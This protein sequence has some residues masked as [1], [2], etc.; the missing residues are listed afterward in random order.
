M[1]DSDDE[2]IAEAAHEAMSMAEGFLED[3]DEPRH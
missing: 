2:D 3:D 1:T